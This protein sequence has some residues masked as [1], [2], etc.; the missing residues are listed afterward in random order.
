MHVTLRMQIQTDWCQ[1]KRYVILWRNKTKENKEK[2]IKMYRSKKDK[3]N[4]YELY[5]ILGFKNN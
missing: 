4:S 3:F 5:E 1:I 2:E